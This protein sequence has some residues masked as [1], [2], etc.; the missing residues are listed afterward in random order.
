MNNKNQY[1]CCKFCLQTYK[2]K[3]LMKEHVFTS[4]EEDLMYLA[5]TSV[6]NL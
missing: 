5:A 4:H 6:M 1:Y 2:T 3:K